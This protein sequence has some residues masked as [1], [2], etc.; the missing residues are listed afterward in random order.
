MTCLRFLGG[1][2]IQGAH[3]APGGRAGQ[4]RR[5]ALLAL[6]ATA[7]T[8]AV[9]RE[10]L[11][12]YLWPEADAERGRRLLSESLYVLRKALGAGALVSEGDSIRLDPEFVSC[13]VP[14]FEAAVERGDLESAISVYAG[15]FLD[16]FFV[17]DAP[18]FERWVES[19]RRRLADCYAKALEQL[20]EGAEAAQDQPG[21]VGWWQRLLAHDPYNSR[22]AL[23]LMQVLAAAGDPANAIQQAEEHASLLERELGVGAPEDILAYAEQLRRERLPAHGEVGL[24]RVQGVPATALPEVR[25]AAPVSVGTHRKVRRRL[26]VTFLAVVAAVAVVTIWPYGPRPAE[27][28]APPGIAVLPFT[29]HGEGLDMWREGMVVLLSTDMNGVGGLRTI[30]SRTLLARWREQ[31]PETGEADRATALEVAQA[32]GARYALLGS[33]VAIGQEVRLSADIYD[34]EGGAQM[35]TVQVEGSHDSVLGLVDRLAVQSLGVVLGQEASELPQLDLAGVTTASIPALT[36]WVEAEALFRRGDYEA[37]VAAYERAVAADST[38]ALAFYGLGNAYGFSGGEGSDRSDRYVEALEQAMRFVDRLPAREV[39]LVRAVH[40]WQQWALQEAEELLQ[41]LLRNYPDYA[42][43]WFILGEVYWHDGPNFPV[44]LEDAQRCFTR[45]V[46]LNPEFAPYR[47]HLIDMAFVDNPDSAEAARLI[48]EYKRLSSASALHTRRVE[49]GFDLAFSHPRF[50][51]QVEAVY[52]AQERRGLALS[53]RTGTLFHGAAMGRGYLGKALEY[54]DRPQ[55]TTDDR[56]CQPVYAH[57]HGFPVPADRLE[58]AAAVLSQIDSTSNLNLVYCAAFLAAAQGRW[59]VHARAVEFFW[60]HWRREVD[61]G[62]SGWQG[63]ANILVLRRGDPEAAVEKLEEVRRYQA[64]PRVRTVLAYALMDLERW[65]EAVPYLAGWDDTYSHRHFHLARAY[66]G[67][68]EHGKAAKEYAFF[69]EAWE[70]A[71]PELQPWVED[72]RRALER[73]VPDR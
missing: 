40:A 29:V 71:D 66:E 2:A 4:A 24:A 53:R 25:G 55:A 62:R 19:E 36:A 59:A 69:V 5:V 45:A 37:A 34:T 26:W 1:A 44:S 72:A 68:G 60:D 48:E 12:A 50:W 70:D 21:A 65:E 33:A 23:R 8:R 14:E 43:G 20:A 54:L 61:A 46:E 6:L 42:E 57:I 9:T 41:R 7:R 11:I 22:Y 15:A 31:V 56:F 64:S 47:V 39:A 32:A 35:G 18:E 10:K 16:G 52:L 30:D 13:D 73:L 28:N 49:F 27:H 58:E 51:P 63:K 38:F 17:K 67:M 3:G